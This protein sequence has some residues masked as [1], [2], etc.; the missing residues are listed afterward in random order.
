MVDIFALVL[1]HG[2]MVVA[3]WRMIGRDALDREG[4]QGSGSSPADA[5]QPGA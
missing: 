5:D 3:I 4:P 1:T 2:L